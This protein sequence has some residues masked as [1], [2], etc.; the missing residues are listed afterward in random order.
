MALILSPY[1]TASYDEIG[2]LKPDEVD[3]FTGYRYYTAGQLSLANWITLLKNMGLSLAA[4]TEIIHQY[5]DAD[6]LRRY[7]QIK[8]AEVKQEAQEAAGRLQL[9]ETMIKRLGKDE[10]IMNYDV[11]VKEIP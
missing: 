7:L 3:G 2:L 8:Y 11:S 1:L 6:A 10:L 5:G 4:I 9:L